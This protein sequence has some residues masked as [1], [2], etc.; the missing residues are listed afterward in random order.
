MGPQITL[1]AFGGPSVISV[2]VLLFA[3]NYAGAFFAPQKPGF[4]GFRRN[5]WP[6][7]LQK[8]IRNAFRRDLR[9]LAHF[10]VSAPG[11]H[12]LSQAPHAVSIIPMI[13]T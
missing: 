5:A 8:Q 1:I 3:K 13:D 10:A 7:P 6:A 4:P 9:P 11:G 12:S 2:I